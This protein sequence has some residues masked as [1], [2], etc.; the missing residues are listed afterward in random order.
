MKFH[1]HQHSAHQ[2]KKCNEQLRSIWSQQFTE[3]QKGFRVPSHRLIKDSWQHFP[4]TIS[5][6][7][8][9]S[10]CRLNNCHSSKRKTNCRSWYIYDAQVL[11]IPKVH[12]SKLGKA[13]YYPKWCFLSLHLHCLREFWETNFK[14]AIIVSLQIITHASYVLIFP[15][16]ST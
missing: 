7:Q 16:R 11:C 9:I 4:V 3:L 1:S 2:K 13:I 15:S 8:S 6:H 14:H 5:E 12:M 10:R